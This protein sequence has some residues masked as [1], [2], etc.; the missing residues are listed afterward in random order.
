M[1]ISC[2][3]SWCRRSC[4]LFLSD[5]TFPV[6]IL[7]NLVDDAL[8]AGYALICIRLLMFG[9]CCGIS[10]FLGL[11]LYFFLLMLSSHSLLIVP[12]F[13]I[14]YLVSCSVISWICL[15]VLGSQHRSLALLWDGLN[16]LME[17]W[18]KSYMDDTFVIHNAEH[19]QQFFTYLNSLNSIYS[20]QQRLQTNEDPSPSWTHWSL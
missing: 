10:G 13:S 15:N 2:S 5:C 12:K 3:I 8:I 7:T 9:P 20:S 17:S 6:A 14:L 11:S 19:T 18:S 16:A 4:S 1:S